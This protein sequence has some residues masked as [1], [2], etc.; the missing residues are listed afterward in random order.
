MLQNAF[1]VDDGARG[2][3]LLARLGLGDGYELQRPAH[4]PFVGATVQAFV[5]RCPLDQSGD[6]RRDLVVA[7]VR[8]WNEEAIDDVT[9][10]LVEQAVSMEDR[11]VEVGV[12]SLPRETHLLGWITREQY[13]ECFAA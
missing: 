13:P 2:A 7:R 9:A 1:R 4:G 6:A 5:D 10:T 3:G 8:L 11:L 12:G